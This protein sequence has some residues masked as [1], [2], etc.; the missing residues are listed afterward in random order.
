[1]V[2]IV[3]RDGV[4]AGTKVYVVNGDG[5]LGA[6]IHHVESAA[7][8]KFAANDTVRVTLVVVAELDVDAIETV[9][10]A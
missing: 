3:S 5:S 1:M 2:R 8:D 9:K 4:G 7:I 6:E 10:S